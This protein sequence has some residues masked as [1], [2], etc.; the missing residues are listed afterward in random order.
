VASPKVVATIL[1]RNRRE[2]LRE[3]LR[4]VLAQTRPVDEL[5]VVDNESTDGTLEMLAE[6]FPD[7]AVVALAEN[8]GATGGFYEAIAAGMRL[9]AAWLWLLDD[10]SI[11]S[12]DALAEL[13]AVL[14]G[15]NGVPAPSVL[16]SRVEWRDGRPHVMNF[17]VVRPD[18]GQQLADAVRLRLLPLRAASWVSLMISSEAVERAGMPLRQFFYQADDIEYTARILRDSTGYYVPRSVVVHSTPTQHTAVDDDH[19]FRFHIR[20]T[21]LMIRGRAWEAREK[22]GLV[23]VIVWTSLAY[24]RKNRR[25]PLAA[26]RNL[27]SGLVAGFRSPAG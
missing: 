12:P 26:L 9:G 18:D 1:T 13:L 2:L 23:W 19:R 20:N 14:D 22:P 11:A 3:S 17:P 25:R 15:L 8:Q 21:V 27:L 4:A 10:D 16:C 7:V 5:V 24:L 6:E